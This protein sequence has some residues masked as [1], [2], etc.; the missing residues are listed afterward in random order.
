M[1]FMSQSGLSDPGYEKE[2]DAWYV[3]HLR[4]MV[5]VPGISSAQ[6]FKTV[7]RG[8]SPSL[9]IYTIASAEVFSDP[10]YQSVRGMGDWLPLIQKRHY[11]RNLFEGLDTA[12]DVP[13]DCVLIVADREG[14]A[15]LPGLTLTWLKT[16][17]LDR[18]TLYRGI[19]V[20]MRTA[21]EAFT[22]DGVGVYRPVGARAVQR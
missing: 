11:R 1:I 10:Y 6:R 5:T 20:V 8:Y 13:V 17:G 15:E 22:E 19:A 2:W 3:E 12:P 14:P 7:S 18:S 16:V 9:A 4:I 21:A